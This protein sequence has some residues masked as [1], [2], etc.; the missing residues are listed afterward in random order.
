MAR[1]GMDE[2]QVVQMIDTAQA[3]PA[4][5]RQ[6]IQAMI[7]HLDGQIELAR[8]TIAHRARAAHD[9]GEH[10]IQ[11][12]AVA[13]I[14]SYIYLQQRRELARHLEAWESGHDKRIDDPRQN[15]TS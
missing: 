11:P 12:A 13:R 7:D 15:G 6:T 14:Q 5:Y 4:V 3:D 2:L 9:F 1:I 8:R 10:H